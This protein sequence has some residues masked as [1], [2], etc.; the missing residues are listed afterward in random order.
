MSEPTVTVV[1][2]AYNAMPYLTRC[3]ESVVEQSLGDHTLEC[4][5]VDDGSTDGTGKE[6][7]RFAAAHP[8]VV[9]VVHQRNSGGPSGPRNVAIAQARGRYVFFLDADDYLGPNAMRRMIDMAER[10]G[11]D[12]VL[13]KYVGVDCEVPRSMFES[14]QEVV[15]LATSRVWNALTPHKLFRRSLLLERGLRFDEDIRIGEDRLFVTKAYLQASVISVVADEDCYYKVK[16]ADQ[17]NITSSYSD[18]GKRFEVA[19]RIMAAIAALSE[20]GPVRDAALLRTF[21]GGLLDSFSWRFPLMEESEQTEAMAVVKAEVERFYTPEL[22]AQLTAPHRIFAH[23]ARHGLRRELIDVIEFLKEERARRRPAHEVVVDQGRAYATYPHFRDGTAGIPD[24][25]YDITGELR[26]DDRLDAVQWRGGRRRGVLRLSGHGFIERV[27]TREPATELVLRRRGDG[28]EVRVPTRPVPT[29]DPDAGPAGFTADLD[30]ARALDGGPLTH[31]VWD[32]Y[33]DVRTQGLSTRRRFG[34]RKAADLAPATSGGSGRLAVKPYY[35]AY[36]NLSLDVT[37]RKK[38]RRPKTLKRRVGSGLRGLGRR[39]GG[40][41]LRRIAR[42]RG[43][44]T[45]S[46][47]P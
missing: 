43:R 45:A 26:Q 39:L 21:R 15:D 22:D 8:A 17:G 28:Q 25:C 3:L 16:R 7:D 20:P 4:L 2:G 44:S 36:G 11:S 34:A 30:P 14:N 19:R 38:T 1:I 40:R 10:N 35:T 5:A 9:R 47:R 6:L 29:A 13:G 37:A 33:L 24:S 12:V 18:L 32:V 46:T 41:K 27:R 42:L 31:G 23:C